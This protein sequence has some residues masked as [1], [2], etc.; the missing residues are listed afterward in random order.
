MVNTTDQHHKITKAKLEGKDINTGSDN[1]P[2]ENLG[3]RIYSYKNVWNE[4]VAGF[5]LHTFNTAFTELT[6]QY[7]SFT[8]EVL[9]SIVST[10]DGKITN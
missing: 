1:L 2:G 3:E 8:G 5:T 10:K 7:I 6:T 4:R 9:H